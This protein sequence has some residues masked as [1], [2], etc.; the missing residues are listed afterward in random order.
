MLESPRISQLKLLPEKF[1]F[2]FR[3]VQ[4][5]ATRDGTTLQG[6]VSKFCV[7][8]YGETVEFTGKYLSHTQTHAHIAAVGS[9]YWDLHDGFS[10]GQ[11]VSC[12]W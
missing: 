3:H 4:A 2:I 1:R 12:V 7:I 5:L 9:A 8:N 10:T 11:P 6:V